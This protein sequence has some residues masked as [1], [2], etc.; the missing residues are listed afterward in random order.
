[1]NAAEYEESICCNVDFDVNA[2]AGDQFES[3]ELYSP[4]S[5]ISV[6]S[7]SCSTVSLRSLSS[8]DSERSTPSSHRKKLTF[9]RI[10]VHQHHLTIGDNP[11]CSSG[12]PVSLDWKLI[13]SDSYNL[14]EYEAM[15]EASRGKAK[16]LARSER[17]SLL[18]ERGYSM[19]TLVRIAEQVDHDNVIRSV[20]KMKLDAMEEYQVMASASVRRLRPRNDHPPTASPF[21]ATRIPRIARLMRKLHN[22]P[23]STS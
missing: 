10:S 4:D 21:K 20:E 15:A 16:R 23:S 19:E 22:T 12:P 1:M 5:S 2:F 11:S 7:L 3:S 17:E 14:D 9:G 6:P 8:I 13:R 18:Q